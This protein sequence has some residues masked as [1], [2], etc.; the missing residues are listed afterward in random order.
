MKPKTA[1]IIIGIFL[2]TGAVK[3]PLY[4]GVGIPCPGCGLTR[5]WRLFFTGQISAAF[6]MHPLFFV[7]PLVLIPKCRKKW[8]IVCI[9]IAFLAVYAARMAA[10]FPTEPPLNYNYNSLL[11]GFLK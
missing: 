6:K 1:I 9:T 10:M 11:G 5:A 8:V 7:P 3:C 4:T 2:L